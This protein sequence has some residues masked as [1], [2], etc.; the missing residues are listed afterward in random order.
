M[1]NDLQIGSLIY[2]IRFKDYGIV[3]ECKW[4]NNVANNYKYYLIHWQNTEEFNINKEDKYR[5]SASY[6]YD[7]IDSGEIIVHEKK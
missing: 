7:K 5:W 2:D 1:K 4:T 6:L 3:I